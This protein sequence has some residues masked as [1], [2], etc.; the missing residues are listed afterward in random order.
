MRVCTRVCV[1]AH[2]HAHV[3]LWRELRAVKMVLGF[4]GHM[5]QNERLR[6]FSDNQNMLRIIETGS[7]NL[8]LQREAIEI[9]SIAMKGQVRIEPEWIQEQNQQADLLRKSHT[10]QG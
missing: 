6:W 3:C 7:R 10:R 4:L 8:G 1:C 9:Y 2:A 5:L